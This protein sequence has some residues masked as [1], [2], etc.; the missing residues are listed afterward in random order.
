MSQT[1]TIYERGRQAWRDAIG[2]WEPGT[3]EHRLFYRMCRPRIGDLVIEISRFRS[4]SFDPDSVG[5]LCE[6][7]YPEGVDPEADPDVPVE[8]YVVEP[9]DKPGVMQGWRNARFVALPAENAPNW[10]QPQIRSR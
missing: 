4:L 6:L 10:P 5:W 7:Q 1:R 9:L 8:R 2:N 3:Y